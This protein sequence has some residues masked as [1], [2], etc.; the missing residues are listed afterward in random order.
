MAISL[1]E[2]VAMS[3]D[4]VYRA[5]G[6]EAIVLDLKSGIYFGLNEVGKRIWEL[7]LEHDLRSVCQHL[8]T[9]FDG[10]PD[11]IERDVLELVDAL[12]AKGLVVVAPTSP[13]TDSQ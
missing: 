2:R 7:T 9:E 1:D 12:M 10:Q 3:D 4:V 13:G 5:L 6:V 8:L 11:V